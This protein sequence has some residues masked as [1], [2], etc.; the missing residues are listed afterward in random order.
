MQLKSSLR[1]KLRAATCSLL[2]VTA[3]SAA[4]AN[5]GTRWTVEGASLLYAEN[6][7]T[8][9]FE[10]LLIVKRNFGAGQML[11]GKFVFDA[12]TGASPTGAAAT[13][14][15]QTFTTPSGNRYTTQTGEVPLR[16]FQ[17]QRGSGDVSWTKPLNR[18][19][20]SVLSAHVSAE[21]DYQSV[22]ATG[23]I[24]ADFNQKLTTFSLG[25]GYNSDRINPVSGVPDGLTRVNPNLTHEETRSKHIADGMLGVTQILTPRWLVQVNF[26]YAKED[27]YLTEPYKIIS[28]VDTLTGETRTG[29]YLYEKRP[30][31]RVRQSVFASTAYHFASDILHVS[32]R[33]YWDDWGIRSHTVDLKYDLELS[34]KVNLEP[35][36]RF[37][38][39]SAADFYTYSLPRG[40]AVPE[41]ATSDYRF[42][43]LNTQT[44]GAKIGIRTADLQEFSFRLE[45]MR[46]S[47]NEHPDEA[48]GVQQ[49]Y[50]MFPPIDI[51]ILQVGYSIGIP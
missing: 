39:Q 49:N 7:R 28:L 1:V 46:Q 21:T 42:G 41:F 47:G 10:P 11:E 48:V 37:Y 17:D 16:K 18:R 33:N 6:K 2:A 29:D 20:K 14:R 19:F 27:G 35:H 13:N 23:T 45:Y 22:G 36:M 25:G 5:F 51:L 31:A 26:S 32:Y 30:D 43:T 38:H 8:T 44:I 34:D 50:S 3:G 15:S 4:A 24:T 12:M 9:V 40:G